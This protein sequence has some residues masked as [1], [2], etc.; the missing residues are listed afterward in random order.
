MTPTLLRAAALF[1][2]LSLTTATPA[3]M[4]PGSLGIGGIA[5]AGKASLFSSAA[6][7]LLPWEPKLNESLP[8]E[9]VLPD[10]S[11]SRDTSDDYKS[12]EQRQATLGEEELRRR[13]DED[14]GKRRQLDLL[15]EYT[16]WEAQR[17]DEAIDEL[18]RRID[19]L[20]KA[21]KAVEAA[22]DPQAL[23][24]ATALEDQAKLLV[25]Q[26]KNQA[27]AEVQNKQGARAAAIATQQDQ[28]NSAQAD[29]LSLE[30][31]PTKTMTVTQGLNVR[32]GPGTSYD[33]VGELQP[34]TQVQVNAKGHGFYRLTDNTFASEQGLADPGTNQGASGPAPQ[35]ERSKYA[36]Q[37]YVANVDSQAAVDACTG[38]L[39][40]SPEVSKYAGKAYYPIH[41]NCHGLPILSL[42]NGDKVFIDGVGAFVVVGSRDVTRGDGASA[43]K[44]MP[45]TTLLQ[46][47]YTTG[48]KMRVVALDPA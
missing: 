45:G 28:R 38:G 36:W 23:K 27:K 6:A 42:K 41:N 18:S 5:S 10:P 22:T 47:C 26:A 37:T 32:N 3:V 25:E 30:E 17:T 21:H 7:P 29:T 43:L 8:G 12:W 39:T 2:S 33:K 35:P 16:R 4:Q 24:D 11:A 44:G 1:A 13:V 14:Q 15:S 34:G 19:L 31:F 20:D 46:T 48:D 40:Y 9:I